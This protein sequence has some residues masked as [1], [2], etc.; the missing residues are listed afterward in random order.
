MITTDVSEA[1]RLGLS[2]V[3]PAYNEEALIAQTVRHVARV[4][5]DL[6]HHFEI[7]VVDDGSRDRTP[8]ILAQLQVDNPEL[9]LRVITHSVNQGYGAALASGFDAARN[10]LVLMLD[11]DGQFEVAEVIHF[12]G[13]LDDNTD[14]VIGWRA[15]RAD[16]V[17]RKLN[18]WGWKL[19][20]NALFGYTARDADCAFKLFRRPVWES[21]TVHAR[22]ATF[23]AELLVKARRLGFPIKELPVSHLPRRAGSPTGA[24][25]KVIARA[26][27]ELIK[28]RMHLEHDLALDTRV[29]TGRFAEAH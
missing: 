16:P 1:R 10:D 4:L 8:Q 29:P 27:R 7:I 12:L 19:L 18:A 28:L 5:R 17:M 11:A 14:M 3:L 26:F 2:A 21:M 9:H 23:S 25:P 13:A 15:R 6:M 22:G 24:H 20:I